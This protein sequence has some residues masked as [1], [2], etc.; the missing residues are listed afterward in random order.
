MVDLPRSVTDWFL[1]SARPRPHLIAVC[2]NALM[3]MSCQKVYDPPY[4]A[5]WSGIAP[6]AALGDSVLIEYGGLQKMWWFQRSHDMTPDF[7]Y[8]CTEMV[9]IM[10]AFH[11]FH[12]LPECRLC[13]LDEEE[14]PTWTQ[15]QREW[16]DGGGG[17]AE[18]A[19][20]WAPLLHR[21]HILSS[22]ATAL[23]A[24]ELIARGLL[25]GKTKTDRK[26]CYLFP[27]IFQHIWNYEVET[28]ILVNC[29]PILP[30]AFA[31]WSHIFYASNHT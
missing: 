17:N 22:F 23:L 5:R 2:G 19:L 14:E 9:I 28:K 29:T 10:R 25:I 20:C 30:D 31:L 13:H 8:Q 16:W 15:E 24:Y 4:F 26:S 3:F 7:K 1:H 11:Y 6:S 21:L 27:G 12:P 18:Y